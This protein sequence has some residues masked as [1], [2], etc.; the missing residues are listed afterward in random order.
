MVSLADG[1]FKRGVGA[2]RG[3]AAG[4]GRGSNIGRVSTA[5][6]GV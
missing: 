1:L 3:R 6:L 5:A 4:A 2:G